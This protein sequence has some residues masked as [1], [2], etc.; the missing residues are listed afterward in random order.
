MAD[1]RSPMSESAF[2]VPR[3]PAPA[4]ERDP[5]AIPNWCAP[6]SKLMASTSD[7]QPSGAYIVGRLSGAAD[8]G[9]FPENEVDGQYQAEEACEVV[10]AQGVRF[11]ENQR[12]KRENRE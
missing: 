8:I 10:P 4:P 2:T 9:L 6:R 12:E 11:H 7:A 5:A 3:E 1:I